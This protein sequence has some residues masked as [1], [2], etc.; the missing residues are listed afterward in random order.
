MGELIRNLF[1]E[2]FLELPAFRVYV[3]CSV[4]LVVKMQLLGAYTVTLRRRR[5]ETMNPEDAGERAQVVT[6]NHPDVQRAMRAHRNDVE[7]IVPF[8]VLAL[9]AMLAGTSPRATIIA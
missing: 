7:N 9:T 4:V 5:K 6:A 2:S 8:L 1:R 3:V